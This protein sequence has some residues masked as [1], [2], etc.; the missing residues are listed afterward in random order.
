M[1]GHKE[2]SELPLIFVH[3]IPEIVPSVIY[4]LAG[5]AIPL[6]LTALQILAIDLGTDTVP[7]LALGREPA[8]PGTMVRA[9]RPRE[10]GIISH[11]MLAR[12]YL[13]LG[14]LEALLVTGG[15]F[16]VLLAAGS[17]PG[18]PTGAG[19]PLSRIPAVDHDDLGRDLA[20]QIGVPFALR[21]GHSLRPQGDVLGNRHLLRGIAF[22][23]AGH[24]LCTPAAID[25][26]HRGATAR[27]SCSSASC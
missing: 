7:A 13:R 22:A 12:A 1:S 10:A 23:F 20:S 26:K 3:A 2:H 11:A 18:D 17:S 16:L 4:A 5:G 25:L 21:T 14:V 9:P 27:D 24:R 6:R 19:A 8:E 15:Y